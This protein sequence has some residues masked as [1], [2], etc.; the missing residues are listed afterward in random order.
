MDTSLYVEEGGRATP[1]QMVRQHVYVVNGSPEFLDVVRELLQD[2]NYNVTT[3]NFV[4]RSFET[5]EPA[6]PALLIIDL[7]LGE[8]AGWELLGKLERSASTRGIPVLLVSTT[9]RLLDEARSQRVN[10]DKTRYL[11]KPFD[12]DDLLLIIREVIGEA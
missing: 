3:T 7:V 12:L 9:A 8:L 6:R 2:E 11:I 5:I 10:M 4:P 1:E